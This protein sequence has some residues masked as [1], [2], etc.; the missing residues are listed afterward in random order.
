MDAL[1]VLYQGMDRIQQAIDKHQLNRIQND[2]YGH[3]VKQNKITANKIREISWTCYKKEM[4][5][6]LRMLLSSKNEDVKAVYYEYD[7]DNSWTGAIFACRSYNQLNKEDDD[8]A[9]DWNDSYS[10]PIIPDYDNLNIDVSLKDEQSAW[11]FLYAILVLTETYIDIVNP[12][13][14]NLPFCIG[15][16]DQTPITRCTYIS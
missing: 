12:L 8:W 3:C 2:F 9:C 15:F 11:I 6:Q 1:T 10:A 5:H 13:C 16:H 14:S 7:P 4:D